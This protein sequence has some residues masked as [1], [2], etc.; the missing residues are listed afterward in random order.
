M[1]AII[2]SKTYTKIKLRSENDHFWLKNSSKDNIL[3]KKNSNNYTTL[4]SNVVLVTRAFSDS[5]VSKAKKIFKF[6]Y[7]THH[8]IAK[9]DHFSLKF[10]ST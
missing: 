3:F 9:N 10:T 5:L 4:L 1:F 2:I 7:N 6:S 8:L